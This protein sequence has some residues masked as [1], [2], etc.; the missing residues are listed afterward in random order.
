MLEDLIKER[1]KKLRAYKEVASPYPARVCRDVSLSELCSSFT[2]FARSEKRVHI[3]G[4]VWSVR[5]QGSIIFI[6]L[7]DAQGKIQLVAN[8]AK[9]ENFTLIQETLD[10]G[11]FVEAYGSAAVTKRGEKSLMVQRIRIITKSIRPIPDDWYGLENIETRLRKRYLDIL[12]N[13]EV[14]ELFVKKT[15]FWDAV[16]SFLK[17]KAFFE[18]EMP[19]LEMVPGGA[20]TEPFITHHNALDEDFYLR[21]SLEL[22]LKKMLVGGIEQVFEIG[23]IFRNEGVDREHLQDYTQMECYAAYWDYVDMMKFTERLYKHVIKGMFG[24]LTI[25]TSGHKISWGGKW[26]SNSDLK[27][28]Q[29]L[30]LAAGFIRTS[31]TLACLAVWTIVWRLWR[32]CSI[33]PARHA[34]SR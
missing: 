24:T 6:D 25:K 13:Q 19:V 14:R 26:P 21:I 5:D 10:R 17:E 9:T 7:R 22:P 30:I 2:K 4:R 1:I 33:T 27:G 29:S 8:K 23:R 34:S 18:V 32:K 11:D 12:L 20:E 31:G 15:Q 28:E 16:R 3:V